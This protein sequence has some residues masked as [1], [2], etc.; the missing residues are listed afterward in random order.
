MTGKC[1]LI[2]KYVCRLSAREGE[3]Q[4][5]WRAQDEATRAAFLAA[6]AG[7]GWG[8]GIDEIIQRSENFVK[9]C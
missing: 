5:S 8:M 7:A 3:T 4:E 2:K 9:V 6:Q 1:F